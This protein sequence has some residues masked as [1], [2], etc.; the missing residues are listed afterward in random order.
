MVERIAT[1]DDNATTQ[2]SDDFR[3]RDLTEHR[4]I[5]QNQQ[6]IGVEHVERGNR[7]LAMDHRVRTADRGIE[8]A[9]ASPAFDQICDDFNRERIAHVVRTRFE[10]QPP[11]AD[12]HAVEPA[13]FFL[14]EV[15]DPARLIIVNA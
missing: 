15:N 13:E 6:G 12:R 5:R 2:T 10:G 9:N 14:E 1:V 7:D 8:G 3:D 11:N 4:P